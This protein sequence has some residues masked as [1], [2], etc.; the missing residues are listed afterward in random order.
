MTLNNENAAI[1]AAVNAAIEKLRDAILA[2]VLENMP[3]V[4]K[5][6]RH[7]T[8]LVR[9]VM[10][11][12]RYASDAKYCATCQRGLMP[13]SKLLK[14][15]KLPAAQFHD[16]IENAI[17]SGQIERCDDPDTGLLCYRIPVK[18]TQP[19]PD[20]AALDDPEQDSHEWDFRKA[21]EKARRE[22]QM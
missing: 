13:H 17:E 16:E 9:F 10:R 21:L 2:A 5:A 18:Q 12:R 7:K 8:R 19:Q 14:L 11:A 20:L 1:E 22:Q 3:G 6:R 4:Q 15:S